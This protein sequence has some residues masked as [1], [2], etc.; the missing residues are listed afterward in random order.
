M[1]GGPLSENYG[2][3]KLILTTFALFLV[4]T[5]GCAL[6]P[7]WPAFL[8]FRFLTGAAASSPIVIVPGQLADLYNNSVARGRAFVWMMVV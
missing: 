8:I 3:R 4:W 2:R 5:L 1:K 7:N 6:A